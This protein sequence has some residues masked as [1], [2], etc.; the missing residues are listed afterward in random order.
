M[1]NQDELK[2]KLESFITKI[3]EM[4]DNYDIAELR[5]DVF[6]REIYGGAGYI[7]DSEPTKQKFSITFYLHK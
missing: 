5:T 1:N 2:E 6:S 4:K 3:Q 7:I